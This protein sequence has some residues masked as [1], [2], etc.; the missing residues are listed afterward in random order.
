MISDEARRRA[1]KEYTFWEWLKRICSGKPHFTIGDDQLDR[2]YLIPR[3]RWVNVYLHRTKKSDDGRAL[4]D[5][6]WRSV[7][8]LIAGDL[9][10]EYFPDPV[11]VGKPT[12]LIVRH[13]RKIPKW[14]PVY[15]RASA[16]H[17]LVQPNPERPAWT[18][19]ITGP[20]LRKWGFWCTDGEFAKWVAFSRY[21]KHGCD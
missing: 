7:S 21:R 18:I 15:R 13:G 2:W 6:P 8:F 3:N 10:E 5:H 16:A 20:K 1:P 12:H 19:F 14:L 11:W 4:H 17:R 9:F